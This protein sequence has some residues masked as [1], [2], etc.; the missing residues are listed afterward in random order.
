VNYTPG[1]IIGKSLENIAESEI[2]L[3]QIAVGRF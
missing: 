3:A 2:K 1:C